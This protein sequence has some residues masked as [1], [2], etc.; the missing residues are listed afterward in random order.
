MVN[1]EPKRNCPFYIYCNNTAECQNFT[2]FND[3]AFDSCLQNVT[4]L[5]TWISRSFAL[6]SSVQFL[7]SNNQLILNQ[8]FDLSSLINI[9]K[10]VLR[11]VNKVAFTYF[12]NLAGVELTLSLSDN[13]TEELSNFP[14][15]IEYSRMNFYSRGQ[16]IKCESIQQNET[17]ANIFNSFVNKLTFNFVKFEPSFCVE[18]FRNMSLTYLI[19]SNTNSWRLNPKVNTSEYLNIRIDHLEISYSK[20]IKFTLD[21]TTLNY[22][23][24]AHTRSIN[25]VSL[26][27]NTIQP[28]SLFKDLKDLKSLIL[29]LNNMKSFLHHHGDVEWMIYL[30]YNITAPR[31]LWNNRLTLVDH[32]YIQEQIFTLVF[33]FQLNIDPTVVAS[34]F[35]YYMYY[36]PDEDFCLFINFPHSQLVVLLI[37]NSPNT[38]CTM[39]SLLQYVYNNYQPNNL[40]SYYEKIPNFDRYLNS[41]DLESRAKLCTI[42]PASY[43][44]S[45][46]DMYDLKQ[47][48]D[49]AKSILLTYLGPLISLFGVLSNLMVILVILHNKIK[50]KSKQAIDVINKSNSRQLVFLIEQPLYKYMLINAILSEIYCVMSLFDLS[51]QCVPAMLYDG[52][53]QN[54]KHFSYSYCF[55]KDLA[56]SYLTSTVKLTSNIMILQ[57]SINRYIL[58]GRD[59]AKFIVKLAGFKIKKVFV[60]SFISSNLLSVIVIFQQLRLSSKIIYQQEALIN[61]EYNNVLDFSQVLPWFSHY[62]NLYFGGLSTIMAF[63]ILYHQVRYTFFCLASLIIDI[64]TIKRL[65]QVLD[66]HAKISKADDEAKKKR[67]AEIK[68]IVM[69]IAFNSVNFLLRLADILAPAF[70][71]TGLIYPAMFYSLCVTLSS[72]L[73]FD[74]LAN[75]FYIFSLSINFFLYY[76]FYSTFQDC[77]ADLLV[78]LQTKLNVKP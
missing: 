64:A 61:T 20:T 11:T 32:R 41:C 62:F 36:Y 67:A 76:V 14:V 68:S 24:V 8:S 28:I 21:Q 15:Y 1:T 42:S 16:I 51:I 52:R 22:D 35:P 27:L 23:L 58:L 44:D 7:T 78:S 45:Y 31:A 26:S 77:F 49:W 55:N 9:Y 40:I 2:S 33:R 70:L 46:F 72:C 18:A 25:L 34:Y 63:S 54:F 56:I 74:Q 37:Y 47:G 43:H 65:K 57:M 69:V 17:L 53:I 50:Y 6:T 30:N 38:T 12:Y 66:E 4:Y 75:V 19:I 13:I 10:Q 73:A 29:E 39:V 5:S 60:F 59:H 48:L 3:L 71:I